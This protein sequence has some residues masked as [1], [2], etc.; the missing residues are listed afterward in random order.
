MKNGSEPILGSVNKTVNQT[1]FF[2]LD[3]GNSLEKNVKD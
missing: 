2:L 3:N 1:N